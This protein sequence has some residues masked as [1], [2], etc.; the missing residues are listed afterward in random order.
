VI[1][2][3]VMANGSFDITLK[4][5]TPASIA[6]PLLIMG[7]AHRFA[8]IIVTESWVPTDQIHGFMEDQL[9]DYT[10][11]PGTIFPEDDNPLP[12]SAGPKYT[13][14]LTDSEA[15]L[16][17]SLQLSGFGLQFLLGDGQRGQFVYRRISLD[18]GSP[19]GVEG[20]D[21]FNYTLD[22]FDVVGTYFDYGPSPLRRRYYFVPDDLDESQLFGDDTA[23]YIPRISFLEMIAVK[24]NLEWV[25]RH[26]GRVDMG[27]VAELYPGEVPLI[28]RM[29]GDDRSDDGDVLEGL[30]AADLSVS[31]SVQDYGS[32]VL[33]AT[34]EGPVLGGGSPTGG[35]DPFGRPV[36]MTHLIDRSDVT[37]ANGPAYASVEANKINSPKQEISVSTTTHDGLDNVVCGQPVDIH[38]PLLYLID[39]SV[40]PTRRH[41]GEWV[42]PLRTRVVSHTWPVRSGMGVYLRRF[43][44]A[45][46]GGT[47]IPIPPTG[48]YEV[49]DLTPYVEFEDGSASITVGDPPRPTFPAPSAPPQLDPDDPLLSTEGQGHVATQTRLAEAEAG[50]TAVAEPT[51]PIPGGLGVTLDEILDDITSYLYAHRNDP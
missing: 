40:A 17:G 13:G 3:T 20:S 39:G 35:F 1:T 30:T 34:G 25:I 38:D 6:L 26:H 11:Q 29:G 21:L 19:P 41:R 22:G 4:P 50:I 10:S 47:L 51:N 45:D 15:S 42:V 48:D 23:G 14:V 36:E 28:T 24:W 43:I 46:P 27:R 2:E 16:G 33:L 9:Y 12:Y 37:G 49:I 18:V 7:A 8:Q 5:E 44:G 32:G 31:M